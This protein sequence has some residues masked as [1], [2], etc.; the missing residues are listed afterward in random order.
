MATLTETAFYARKAINWGLIGLVSLVILRIVFN[1]AID[2]I[3]QAFPPPLL[4]PNNALG[5]LPKINFPQVA[6]PSGT[7]TYRFETISGTVPEASEAAR[8]YFLPKNRSNFL[9]L[10]NVETTV[11]RIGFTSNPINLMPTLYR[12][13]DPK[14]QLRSIEADIIN[15]HYK[16]SYAFIHDLGIF[17][18]KELPNRDTAQREALSMLQS[19]GLNP[20]DLDPAKIDVKYLSLAGAS[21]QPTTSQSQADAAK[22]ILRRMDYDSMPIVSESPEYGPVMLIL[23][24]SRAQDQRV[25]S[26]EYQYWPID[27]STTGVYKLKT[28]AE[29]FE[30][31]K[32]G[33]A[34]YATFKPNESQIAITNVYVAYFDSLTPQFYMQPVFVFEGDPQ[35]RAYVPAVAAPWIEE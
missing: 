17:S 18:Q 6:S 5:K 28:S 10:T 22:V 24:G 14:N 33:K 3:R 2:A 34:Y 20:P 13:T 11:G 8:V 16:L 21:L 1:I 31:L 27:T 4:V 25:L 9:S 7:L 29:A 32:E 19:L 30:E 26:F 23:S 15:N 12:W 35:F